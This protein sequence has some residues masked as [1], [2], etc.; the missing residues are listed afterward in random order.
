MSTTPTPTQP[1]IARLFIYPIK[2]CAGI[3]LPQARLTE[4]GLLH[5][6]W[7]MLVDAQGRFVSQRELARMALI[8]PE[9]EGA[10]LRVRAP[11]TRLSASPPSRPSRRTQRN[12]TSAP[13]VKR[14]RNPAP[15]LA[16][17]SLST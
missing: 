9:I 12:P 7:F 14:R 4:T 8:R 11:C 10:Q 16:K 13:S 17:D 6:R 2:S 15:V 1:H 5:D 3:E